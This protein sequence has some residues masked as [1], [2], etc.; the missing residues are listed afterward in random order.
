MEYT[1]SRKITSQNCEM[2]TDF[3]FLFD[4]LIRFLSRK[5]PFG[6]SVLHIPIKWLVFST[7]ENKW[8]PVRKLAIKECILLEQAQNEGSIDLRKSFFQ[9]GR[10]SSRIIE[11]PCFAKQNVRN[12]I[13]Q[14]IYC[15][16]EF[17]CES[18]DFSRNIFPSP[19]R[20]Q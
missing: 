18:L 14:N 9:F 11:T 16:I 2:W 17:F 13:R 7:I 8:F 3:Y 4:V 10:K 19:K 15:K 20:F 1:V 12:G 5:A 6:I